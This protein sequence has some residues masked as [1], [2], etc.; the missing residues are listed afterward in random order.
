MRFFIGITI[1]PLNARNRHFFHDIAHSPSP[2]S[3]PLRRIFN[4]ALSGFV[5]LS[6]LGIRHSSLIRFFFS[7][8]PIENPKSQIDNSDR[9]AIHI[10]CKSAK[11]ATGRQPLASRGKGNPMKDR[12]RQVP[13]STRS[14]RTPLSRSAT[15]SR[16]FQDLGKSTYKTQTKFIQ[17]RECDLFSGSV[18]AIYNFNT[19]KCLNFLARRFASLVD[20]TTS[21]AEAHGIR[22]PLTVEGYSFSLGEKVRMRDRLVLSAPHSPLT[23]LS[24]HCT[25][26][27]GTERFQILF[28]FDHAVPTTYATSKSAHADFGGDVAPPE[29]SGIGIPI[30]TLSW[31]SPA[32]SSVVNRKSKIES[33]SSLPGF[34]RGPI[35]KMSTK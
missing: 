3:L 29:I 11:A 15:R 30:P 9:C 10:K 22:M 2:R 28:D 23:T 7:R 31:L 20:N 35:S 12:A 19:I 8:I 5:I 13:G 17:N 18:S 1:S 32:Q 16:R 14:R 4:L 21:V 26:S 25:E 27:N 24:R 34:L 33:G 6:S